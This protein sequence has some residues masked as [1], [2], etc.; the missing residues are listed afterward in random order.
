MT[1]QIMGKISVRPPKHYWLISMLK[2]QT[3]HL[4]TGWVLVYIVYI[5]Q[6]MVYDLYKSYPLFVGGHFHIDW[7]MI[8]I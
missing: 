1:K 4:E 5:C 8:Y 7:S 2:I 3:D 6:Q